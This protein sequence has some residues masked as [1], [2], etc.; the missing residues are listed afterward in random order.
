MT[1][2]FALLRRLVFGFSFVI[3]AIIV[4]VMSTD[5]ST[6]T[7]SA[8]PRA[9]PARTIPVPS[10][11]SPQMQTL[12]AGAPPANW[13]TAP[14]NVDEWRTLS[15]P[16]AGRNLPALRERLGVKTEPM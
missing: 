3:V 8:E 15:A 6:Q 7:N 16:S 11:V 13:N 10:T 12:I 2:S 5:A 4:L 1:N 9:V 14:T